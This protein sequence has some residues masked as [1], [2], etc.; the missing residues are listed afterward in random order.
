MPDAGTK[1][2][3]Y[4][5]RSKLGEGG[6]GEVYL[7][8]DTQLDRDIALK[9]LTPEVARDQQR[10]H[11]FLQ[12]ARAASAL[13]HPNVAHIYEIGEVDSAHF[14]AMEFVEGESLDRKIG[15]RPLA[16]SE[17]LEIGIQIADALD[18]AH[19]KGIT[20]RDIKSANVMITPRGRVK[21]L[22]F[23]LAKLAGPSSDTHTSDSEMATR[24]KTSPGVVMGTVNYMSPEQALGREVDHRSDIFSFGVVLYEMATGQLPF[25]GNTVTE[26]IDRI[27]HSQP[28]AI[29]R[30]N[31]EVPAELEIIVKKALRKN[32]EERYQ[33]IHDLLIDLKDLKREAEVASSL[34][35]S[36][37]PPEL[38]GKETVNYSAAQLSNVLQQT[39]ISP[40]MSTAEVSAAPSAS[41]AEYIVSEIK[42]HK[43]AFAGIVVAVVLAAL[44]L[45]G[46]MAYRLSRS[47]SV[48]A[49]NGVRF[50]RLTSGGKI[51]NEIIQGGVS[52]SPDG[53]Y[54]VFETS[55]TQGRVS[56]YIRQIST[57]SLVRIFGP[58]ES[59]GG[60]GTAFSPDGEF[61]YFQLNDK[62]N[63]DGA[64]YK[65]PV[66]GG[67]SQKILS[68]IWSSVSFSPDGQRITYV[69]LFPATGESWL[70]VANADGS[71]TPQTISKRTLPE[72]YSKDGPSWSPD[73]E[74]IVVGANRLPEVLNATL[75]EVP[76]RGGSEHP[77]TQPQWSEIRRVVWMKDGK[78]LVLTADS[79]FLSFGTQVWQLSYPGGQA[80]RVT[81]DL[82]GY[83][84]MSLSITADDQTIATVQDDSTSYIWLVTPGQDPG[85]QISSGKHEGFLSL[86]TTADGRI[87][88]LDDTGNAMEVWSMKSD[89]SDKRQL[90]SDATLK[91]C[92][93]VTRDGRYVLFTTNR[94]GAFNIWRMDIDGSNQKQLTTNETFAYAATG[95]K[96]G[97][98]VVYQTLRD[99]KWVVAKVSIEGGETSQLTERQC[100][101]PAISPDGKS[102]ACFSP[103]E[104]ASFKWKVAILPY[105]GG[106]PTRLIDAPDTLYLDS[107]M[108]WTP[109]GRAIAYV[110][111][112]NG[113]SNIYS[114]PIDGGPASAL[115]K[116]KSDYIAAFNWTR[117][118]KQ[119][120]LGHGPS[121]EDVVLIKDFR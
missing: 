68:G 99:G 14:I 7:A 110:D 81:N 8:R 112:G 118:G 64:L 6:M 15:G 47:K 44:I 115:T 82:N 32:R 107:G 61:V 90:T 57:N 22:D 29:A 45:G 3:R 79:S 31:Y 106:K 36:V 54:V 24:V 4:E 94:S 55:D 84:S 17:L 20:H 25:T 5:I 37:P 30:L 33:T 87:V 108:K 49:P 62:A 86:D 101:Y 98:S 113:T 26:T 72:Y 89:G 77:I 19:A 76:A 27:T 52:I 1:L 21:V 97:S 50:V 40:A 109:D 117:D 116:F 39:D 95:S 28:Q 58:A 71:G 41:S 88:Y 96:D 103:D 18:E 69:R 70:V 83:G 93:A 9:T 80:R 85:H 63:P 65:V 2:G 66:L 74:K 67:S 11:R 59:A 56:T 78:G 51:G 120:V 23:G 48:A 73:G 105:E 114:Q 43:Q 35:R 100:V 102:I 10:L 34:E 92:A 12:E 60:S 104:T 38:T 53:K 121:I 111:A 16:I 119:L 91:V 13:S 42:R 46:F 75:V